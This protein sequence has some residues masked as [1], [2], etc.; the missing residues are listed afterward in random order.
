MTVNAMFLMFVAGALA[1]VGI[2]TGSIHTVI[3]AMVIA[4]GFEPLTRVALGAVGGGSALRRGLVDT[5][6]GYLALLLGAVVASVLL[7]AFGKVILEGPDSYL[8]SSS[9]VRYWSST[10]PASLF[11]SLL[12][13]AAGA[14]LVA[15]NRTVLTAGVMIA[16]ALIP[17]AALVG[18]GVVAGNG[19]VA[20]GALAR[21]LLDVLLVVGMSLL[22]FWWKRATVQRRDAKD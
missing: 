22:V 3:G 7:P 13:G 17:A 4:P 6:K 15:T 2:T 14:I 20:G 12:A 18:A 8:E 1:V 10:D 5:G 21:W 9:L 16:L 19:E 11:V